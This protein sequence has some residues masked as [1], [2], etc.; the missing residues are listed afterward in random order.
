MSGIVGAAVNVYVGGKVIQG[1]RRIKPKKREG[2]SHGKRRR[3][4]R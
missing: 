1:A 3:R 2:D 4:S